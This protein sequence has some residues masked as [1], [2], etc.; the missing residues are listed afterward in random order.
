[1]EADEFKKGQSIPDCE[2]M[3][4][5]MRKNDPPVR[6]TYKIVLNGAS[7]PRNYLFL[8]LDPAAEGKKHNIL[9]SVIVIILWCRTVPLWPWGLKLTF[10][11]IP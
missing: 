5:W 9:T 6:L 7:A 8:V 11:L 2:L 10:V 3:M 4:E 1:M